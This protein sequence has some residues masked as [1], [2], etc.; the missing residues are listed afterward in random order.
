MTNTRKMVMIAILSALSFVLMLFSFPL[1]PGASFLKVDFSIIPTFLALIMYDY[2]SS[3]G[4]LIL[5]SLLKLLLDNRGAETYIGL[6][7]NIV[8]LSLFLASFA[9]LWKNKETLANFIK[10]SIVGTVL[11][12]LS[13]LLLNYVYAVPLYATFANFDIS[14]TIGLGNYLIAM[15]TPFNIVE[16]I[17]MAVIFYLAYVACKPILERYRNS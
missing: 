4:V 12:T 10:A 8:A 9:I 14:A 11:L 16:G 15:V 5:R 13:M 2:K 7:M 6:P 3:F 17:L 1:I